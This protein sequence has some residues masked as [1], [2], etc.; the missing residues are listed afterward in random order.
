MTVERPPRQVERELWQMALEAIT[1]AEKHAKA[2][3]LDVSYTARDGRVAL[4]VSDDGIGLNH[5]DQRAD[6]YG[7]IGMRERA[8]GI[9][10]TMRVDSPDSGGTTITVVLDQTGTER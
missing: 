3:T 5:G 1:N 10:A 8:E 6:R 7:M 9:G 4:R 2:S